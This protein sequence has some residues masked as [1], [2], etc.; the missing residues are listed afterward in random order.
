MFAGHI[1]LLLFTLGGTYMLFNE[2][3][4]LKVLA[5]FALAS[6][7]GLTSFEA[8]IEVLQAYIF[9]LLSALY[10]AEAMSEEH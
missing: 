1:L 6:A 5:P 8:F 10:I 9:T 4:L 2:S 3:I 7:V